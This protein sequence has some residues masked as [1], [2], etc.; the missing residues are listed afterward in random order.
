MILNLILVFLLHREHERN[1]DRLLSRDL[2]DYKT[3]IGDL[4][5]E[6]YQSS[7]TRA[8]EVWRSKAKVKKSGDR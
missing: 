2:V 5:K 7:H 8:I 1:C 3:A 4:K 6:Q